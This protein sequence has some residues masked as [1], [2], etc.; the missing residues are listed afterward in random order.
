MGSAHE[1]D[2]IHDTDTYYLDQL[3]MIGITAA[4]A[5]I[6]L[7]LY[8]FNRP[9]L[10]LLL[11][12]Y[13]HVYILV[14]GFALS[15]IVLVRAA[16]LWKAAG[17]TP[18]AHAHHHDHGAGDHHHHDHCEHDHATP[19]ATPLPMVPHGHDHDHDHSWAPW[20]YVVLLVPIMLFLLGLPVKAIP[21]TAGS[22][23]D[24]THEATLLTRLVG[25]GT[26]A[27]P[28][29]SQEGAVA[30]MLTRLVGVGTAALPQ[31]ALAGAMTLQGNDEPAVWIDFKQ[32]E[33]LAFY[34]HLRKAYENK[35]VQVAGQFVP[36][37]NTDRAFNLSRL[38]IQCCGADAVQLN[39]PVDCRVGVKGFNKE[40]WIRVTGRIEFREYRDRPGVYR[41]VLVV[42]RR[43]DVVATNPD[44]RPYIN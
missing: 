27:L 20:R 43:A 7:T 6:C 22:E 25:V 4:F 2:H 11:Q 12:D 14:V 13:F 42:N 24:V 39:I 41:T 3:C 1:H 19:A 9:M 23:M 26:A 28:A 31:A 40:D 38:R 30:V 37:P 18:A 16:L 15:F 8:F 5:G 32:L 44:P 29:F 35:N 17:G 10:A 34:P 21:L 36:Y 33:Q